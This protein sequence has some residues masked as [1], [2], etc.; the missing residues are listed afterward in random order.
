MKAIKEI[1]I[2]NGYPEEVIDDNINL[3]VTRLKNKN[4]ILTSQAMDS[5]IGENFLAINSCRTNY[6]DDC[7]SV[8]HRVRDK[9][10]L[11]VLEAIYIAIDSPSLYRQRSCHILDIL[12]DTLDTG[13][14]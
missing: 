9:I 8:L 6:Q 5:A 12:G 14:T 2:N 1:F 4:K 3:T 11:N 10:Q 13:V 7:F